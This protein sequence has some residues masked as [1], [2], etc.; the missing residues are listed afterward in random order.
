MILYDAVSWHYT[1]LVIG[2]DQFTGTHIRV[3]LGFSRRDNSK[4]LSNDLLWHPV[5]E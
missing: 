5:L 2:I 1:N 3:S 4:W